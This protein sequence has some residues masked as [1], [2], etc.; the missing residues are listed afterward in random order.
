MLRTATTH[1]SDGDERA[2]AP[3]H[4][5]MKGRPSGEM[6]LPTACCKRCKTTFVDH[7][8]KMYHYDLRE[9]A[10]TTPDIMRS[11]GIRGWAIG[12]LAMANATV[13][14]YRETARQSVAMSMERWLRATNLQSSALGG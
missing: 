3:W 12:V 10:Q 9:H 5:R 1:E 6:C 13:K 7:P 4:Q 8:S 11:A 2:P 14:V